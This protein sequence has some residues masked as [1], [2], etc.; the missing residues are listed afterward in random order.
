MRNADAAEEGSGKRR[1]KVIRALRETQFGLEEKLR[2]MFG[3]KNKT[4]ISI[5]LLSHSVNH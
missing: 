2:K 4:S 3:V 1:S 5:K